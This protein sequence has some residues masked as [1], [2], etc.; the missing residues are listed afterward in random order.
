MILQVNRWIIICLNCG[1]SKEDMIENS[2][3]THKLSSCEIK[4]WKNSL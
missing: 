3:F 4:A 2:S 1:E